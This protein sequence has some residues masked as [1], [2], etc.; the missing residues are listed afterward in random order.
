MV[1]EYWSGWFDL[2]GDLHHVYTAEG[3]TDLRLEYRFSLVRAA[4]RIL[5]KS[6]TCDGC[7]VED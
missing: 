6:K 1:M 4:S 5:G 2:W 3:K 7:F